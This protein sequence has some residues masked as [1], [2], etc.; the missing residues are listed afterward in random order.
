MTNQDVG[1]LIEIKEKMKEL[2]GDAKYI[3]KS[4]PEH[5]WNRAKYYWISAIEC[6]IDNDNDWVSA[7][8]PTFEDTIN[9]LSIDDEEEYEDEEVCED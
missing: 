6:V 5:T 3:L 1:D 2:I 9:E 4:A 7:R 8:T